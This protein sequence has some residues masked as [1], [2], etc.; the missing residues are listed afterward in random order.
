MEEGDKE[1]IIKVWELLQ[2]EKEITKNFFFFIYPII[3][4][5]SFHD[6][7]TFIISDKASIAHIW[8]HDLL[9][10]SIL[11]KIAKTGIE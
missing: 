4:Q 5:F 2:Q 6:L 1:Q 7:R 9:L 3:P 11:L 8:H 10:L